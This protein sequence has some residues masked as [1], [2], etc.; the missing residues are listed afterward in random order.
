MS[1]WSILETILIGPL[2]LLLEL[3]FRI[4]YDLMGNAGIS[5]LFLSLT[6]NLLLLPLYRRAD[7]MQ[8]QARDKEAA[9]REGVLHI[10]KTYTGA[11]RMSMLQTYY[12]QNDYSP[13]HVFRGSVSLLLEIPV[14][15]AAYQFLSRL[16][17]LNGVS[18]GPISDLGAPDAL[19]QI[20]TL[21]VNLL[22]ILMTAIN[23][24]SSAVYLRGFPLKSK[25]QLYG[26]AIFFLI[27]LYSSPS[28]LLFYWMLNN[29]FSLLKNICGR[30]KKHRPSAAGLFSKL[31]FPAPSK[32]AFWMS[33]FF[34]ACFIGVMFPSI[35]ISRFAQEY[36]NP[37]HFYNPLWYLVGSACLAAGTF[38]F[39]FGVIY[40]L[41]GPKG[42]FLFECLVQILCV[43]SI[44]NLLLF[45]EGFGTITSTLVYTEA[46]SYSLQKNV[47]NAAVIPA[48]IALVIL[49]R[50]KLPSLH[51]TVIRSCAIAGILFSV[52]GIVRANTTLKMVWTETT[53]AKPSLQLSRNGKNVIVLFLDRAMGQYMPYLLQEDPELRTRYDGFTWYSNVISFGGH[54]NQSTPSIMGGYEY[55]PV[56]INRRSDCLLEEKHNESLL[57]M[58]LLFS[59]NGYRTTVC[60]P[61]YANYSWIPDLSLFDPYPQITAYNTR[62]MFTTET[63]YMQYVQ[64]NLRNFFCFSLMR[65]SPVFLQAF[66]YDDGL[67]HGTEI[68]KD[69]MYYS[70]QVI[71]SVHEARGMDMN[72]LQSYEVLDQLQSITDIRDDSENCF[73]FFYNDTP[74]NPILLSEPE[75]A[76]SALIDNTEYDAAHTERFTANGTTL[77][78]D[79]L[80]QM[81]HYQSNMSAL[82][83]VADWLDYLR[84]EGVYDN[85]RIIIVSDHGRDLYQLDEFFRSGHAS[86]SDDLMLFLPLLMYKDFGASGFTV[87]DE[88]MTVA[89]TPT[90]A[91]RELIE[92]PVNPFTDN[93]VDNREKTA[94]DQFILSSDDWNIYSNNGVRFLPGAWVSI[95]NNIH[96]PEDWEFYDEAVALTEHAFP[97]Q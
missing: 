46:I 79:D 94:H 76:P 84:A 30:L 59:E 37:Y 83:R 97:D 92:D 38:L 10:K 24:I 68:Y 7:T 29:L 61:P 62:G 57:V 74:H 32:K 70:S 55:T 89:D 60:D 80:F 85:S 33:G 40:W 2:K 26:L 25:L 9:L 28:G 78:V 90:L 19:L 6:V 56:E 34:L 67:Y 3:I 71:S 81:K 11:E 86:S 39:W 41:S 63:D 96:D 53:D 36:V 43:T 14:F 73:L 17:L 51:F 5:I 12:R 75:Y 4:T 65:A 21:R 45:T 82:L 20:G 69:M 95:T 47:L 88:F 1:L 87:S 22:P 52:I 35:C 42:K 50:Y 58:P 49:L 18:F 15:M 93:P 16:E 54:T 48:V 44:L 77:H 27:F 72:F 8:L 64:S 91:F 31:H 66:L 13:F 23:F